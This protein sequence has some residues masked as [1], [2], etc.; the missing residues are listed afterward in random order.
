MVVNH[1][2]LS[3][4]VGAGKHS[5]VILSGNNTLGCHHVRETA[6]VLVVSM[7]L[8]IDTTG[9]PFKKNAETFSMFG[10]NRLRFRVRKPL[11][12]QFHTRALAAISQI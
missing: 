9:V 12:R 8:C 5:R 11:P 10:L 6:P 7:R 3:D 1:V 4:A 2:S